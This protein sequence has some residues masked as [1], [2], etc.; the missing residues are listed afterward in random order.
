MMYLSLKTL[1]TPGDLE[2]R[3]GGLGDIHVETGDG[4]ELFDVEQ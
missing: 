3:W 2:F 1:E 4:K